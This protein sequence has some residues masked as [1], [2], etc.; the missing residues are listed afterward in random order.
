MC[1][2]VRESVSKWKK[3]I[4]KIFKLTI[5]KNITKGSIVRDGW[6]PSARSYYRPPSEKRNIGS[7][8][9]QGLLRSDVNSYLNQRQYH[10]QADK[11]YIGALARSGWLPAFR[12][13][14]GGRF[15][16]SGRT[17]SRTVGIS[18]KFLFSKCLAVMQLHMQHINDKK[19]KKK[20]SMNIIV[21]Y[22]SILIA[23][24][25]QTHHETFYTSN[26][27]FVSKVRLLSSS[28]RKQSRFT[29]LRI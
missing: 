8:A 13:T 2:C 5:N 14:R 19:K 10:R 21:I 25:W 15:S 9:R 28:S 18:L 4:K 23:H 29:N 11:R 26:C 24:L 16:R 27:C 17:R 12:S 6:S 7:L 3:M 1:L 22:S 20:K